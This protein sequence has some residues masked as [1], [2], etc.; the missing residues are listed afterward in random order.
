ME[1]ITHIIKTTWEHIGPAGSGHT[2]HAISCN[3]EKRENRAPYAG[4]ATSR[5][6]RLPQ[7]PADAPSG[8]GAAAHYQRASPTPRG[9]APE[10]P[11]APNGRHLAPRL[12]VRD[13]PDAERWHS[14]RNRPPRR[15]TGRRDR[16]RA[17]PARPH[18]AH[19]WCHSPR[20]PMRA[21]RRAQR[22]QRPLCGSRRPSREPPVSTRGGPATASACV[23]SDADGQ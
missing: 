23:D 18:H 11:K 19:A 13:S 3:L 16:A 6:L 10:P 20:P 1:S 22:S 4:I 8:T 9:A 12:G 7:R 21:C 14:N 15:R 2:E 5:P 17:L